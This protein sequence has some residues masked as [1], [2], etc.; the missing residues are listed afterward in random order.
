MRR[1][2]LKP[3]RPLSSII[4]PKKGKPRAAIEH[5]PRTQDN[6]EFAVGEKFIGAMEHFFGEKYSDLESG[7]GRADLTC[8]DEHGELIK[9]QVVEVINQELRQV[10]DM[11]SDYLNYL[12][13]E[14]AEVFEVFRGCRITLADSGDP[15]YLPSIKTEA[16]RACA[17]QL[18]DWLSGI[19]GEIQTLQCKKMRVLK[20]KVGPSERE[21]S[22]AV[23][24]SDPFSGETQVGFEWGGAG[25][26]YRADEPRGLL[27]TAIGHKIKKN[28]SKPNETFWLL[29]YSTDTI[30]LEDDPDIV[31]S[32][33]LLDTSE[34]PFDDVWYFYPYNNK[35][36]GAIERIW[37]TKIRPKAPSSAAASGRPA[38]D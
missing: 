37:P 35:N 32:R 3:D 17:Q 36:L 19:G 33:A 4:F 11:R 2:P 16:G 30:Y 15:P 38:D 25:P 21:I 24:R 6:L 23:E 14:Y 8:R 26:G 12:A 28:Y 7:P 34:H 20:T 9:I 18:A 22:V 29:A 31:A 10:M 5:L 27:P 13:K 1:K